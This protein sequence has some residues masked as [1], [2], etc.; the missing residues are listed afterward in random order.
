MVYVAFNMHGPIFTYFMSVSMMHDLL[1]APPS[2]KFCTVFMF[3]APEYFFFL[4]NYILC[5]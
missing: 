5:L 2:N 3:K 4:I 1:A